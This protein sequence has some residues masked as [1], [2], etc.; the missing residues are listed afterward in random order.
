[1]TEKEIMT[2]IHNDSPTIEQQL[3][4]WLDEIIENGHNS[5]EYT[6]G[7]VLHDS[8][9]AVRLRPYTNKYHGFC[10]SICAVRLPTEIQRK[11]WF[12]SFLKL[13]CEINPW[14]DVILE[15]V[16]NEHLLSFCK[17]NHFQVLDPFYDTTYVVN[18]ETVM[19]LATMPLGRYT[20]YLTISK[21]E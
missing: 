15:D 9:L 5:S 3:R 18:K 4:R 7:V 21:S 16:E 2:W 6:H 20:D 8:D 11:G 1:M 10:L 12:K 13:C 17:R 14:H 19:N